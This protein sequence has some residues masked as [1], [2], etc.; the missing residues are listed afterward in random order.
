MNGSKK[1]AGPCI[2]LIAIGMLVFSPASMAAERANV[3]PQAPA[4][5]KLDSQR[6]SV[7]ATL[8]QQEKIR[9]AA[10]KLELSPAAYDFGAVSVRKNKSSV[11]VPVAGSGAAPTGNGGSGSLMWSSEYQTSSGT[12]GYQGGTYPGS[13]AA[14]VLQSFFIRNPGTTPLT[15]NKDLKV[16]DD[17]CTGVNTICSFFVESNTCSGVLAPGKGCNVSV[18]FSPLRAGSL[19]ATIPVNFGT[20]PGHQASIQ[21][22]GTGTLPSLGNGRGTARKAN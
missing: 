16:V 7:A 14:A 13:D 3:L 10:D 9:V 12:A 8:S 22:S 18:G 5:G 1:L 19:H 21:L 17:S 4:Q 2:F 15:M 20:N 11:A 6:N